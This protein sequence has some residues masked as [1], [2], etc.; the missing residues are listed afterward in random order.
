MYSNMVSVSSSLYILGYISVYLDEDHSS[1][2]LS[3]VLSL[4]Q[5]YFTFYYTTRPIFFQ[6]L[7]AFSISHEEFYNKCERFSS[8]SHLFFNR[9]EE[10]LENETSLSDL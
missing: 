2:S 3:V 4:P 7:S 6:A 1:G 8:L 5:L 9:K 10:Y